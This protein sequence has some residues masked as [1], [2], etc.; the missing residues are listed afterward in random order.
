MYG[1]TFL[2]EGY[3]DRLSRLPTVSQIQ[4]REP[5]GPGHALKALGRLHLSSIFYT[6]GP[7]VLMVSDRLSKKQ[8]SVFCVHI[9]DINEFKPDLAGSFATKFH[10]SPQQLIRPL[11]SHEGDRIRGNRST[12][13]HSQIWNLDKE[14]GGQISVSNHSL[15]LFV[16]KFYLLSS[17]FQTK[18]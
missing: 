5:G 15:I 3:R 1:P 7:R 14:S 4:L 16:C 9:D 12:I 13:L 10:F 2:E 8:A 6:E 11:F 17:N 18:F